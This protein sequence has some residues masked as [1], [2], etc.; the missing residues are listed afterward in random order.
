MKCQAR[1]EL[2]VPNSLDYLDMVLGFVS[3]TAALAGMPAGEARRL[4]LAVEE[5]FTNALRHGFADG[6]S[7]ELRLHFEA[8]E[9]TARATLAYEGLPFDPDQLPG[10]EAAPAQDVPER[11]L[12]L[13][14]MRALCDEVALRHV[15]RGRVETV[16]VKRYAA[17]AFADSPPPDGEQAPPARQ[18]YAFR[19]MRLEEA[20]EVSR[21]AFLSYGDSYLHSFV[22]FPRQLK[23]MN[24]DGRL[25]SFVAASPGGE[26]AAHGALW[27]ESPQARLA[28]MCSGFT[29]PG[30]RGQGCMEGLATALLGAAG[31]LGLAAVFV[32]AVT[33]HT[34]SQRPVMRHGLRYS[35]LFVAETLPMRFRGIKDDAR[36]RESLVLMMKPLAAGQVPGRLYLPRPYGAMAARILARLGVSAPWDGEGAPP[37]PGSRTLM[38]TGMLEYLA[39]TITVLE[40]GED[41]ADALRA[42]MR[43]LFTQG[44]KVLRLR[45]PLAD[46]AAAAL[47]PVAGELG[48]FFCGAALSETGPQVI[49]QHLGGLFYDYSNIRLAS[50]EGQELLDF[51]RDSDPMQEG[52]AQRPAV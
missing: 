6:A 35:A 50:E 51:V 3:Q 17:P 19:P 46:P 26:V 33:T 36:Q 14:L 38:V 27:R 34:Y 23:A 20:V 4:E 18:E 24:E 45:L 37:Q 40:Y 22:Y 48:F 16:L 12:G 5:V 44:A 8:R 15:G 47:G 11:G 41:F 28:E 30:R 42:Q 39:A 1:A 10:R 31:D 25:H 49:L 32:K 7:G 29:R 2:A 13:A 9:G 52:P 43:A 21:M